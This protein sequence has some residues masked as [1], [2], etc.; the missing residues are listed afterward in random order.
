MPVLHRSVRYNCR[1]MCL[2]GR[3]LLIRP[4]LF[5]AD[6][7]NYRETRY[8]TPWARADSAETSLET[9]TLP[10]VVRRLTGQA[11][12]PFGVALLDCQ[13]ATVANETCEELFTPL[14]PHI[15]ASALAA[16]RARAG[17]A[18]G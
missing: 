2:D 11:T 7:G 18:R 13:D 12:A 6:D 10:D 16:A 1:V 17:T 3:I 14:A 15:A 9:F 5:M 8:F 4:K